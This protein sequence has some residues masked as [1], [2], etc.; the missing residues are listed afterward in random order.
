MRNLLA[1][2]LLAS[3]AS[4]SS[5]ASQAAPKPV[6]APILSPEQ[7]AEVRHA[8]VEW[9]ECEECTEGQL[10]RVVKFG[11]LVVPSLGATLREGPPP[12]SIEEL[13]QHLLANYRNL[14]EYQSTHPDEPVKLPM[15]EA[16][17]VKTY[18]DNYVALYQVRAATALGTIGG[19]AAREA[20]LSARPVRSD[21]RSA[22]EQALAKL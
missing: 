9:F 1:M 13:R 6:G 21:V 17:Y 7:A 12:A 5:C 8:L 4:L 14:A 15:G 11:Q 10:D 22:V 16:E 19:P 3:V 20:L 2:T 18:L